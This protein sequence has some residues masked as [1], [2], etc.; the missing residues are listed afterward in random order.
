[1]T[2]R[3]QKGAI[4]VSETEQNQPKLQSWIEPELHVLDIAETAVFPGV[5]A[6]GSIF[7]DCTNS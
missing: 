1:M 2:V 5:G 7:P 3:S 6:D 4:S